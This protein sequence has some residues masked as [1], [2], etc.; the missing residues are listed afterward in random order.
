MMKKLWLI[1]LLFNAASITMVAQDTDFNKAEIQRALDLI[2]K[3]DEKSLIKKWYIQNIENAFKALSLFTMVTM[4][5]DEARHLVAATT[6]QDQ[7]EQ[8]K[9]DCDNQLEW[10]NDLIIKPLEDLNTYESNELADTLI[11]KAE[12]RRSVLDIEKIIP[13]LNPEDVVTQDDIHI[14]NIAVSDPAFDGKAYAEAIN[15]CQNCVGT[16]KIIDVEGCNVQR[17]V[18]EM[19]SYFWYDEDEAQSLKMAR[20]ASNIKAEFEKAG[21][22]TEPMDI[23]QNGMMQSFAELVN[24]MPQSQREQEKRLKLINMCQTN[25]L[26]N[27]SHSFGLNCQSVKDVFQ[28]LSAQFSKE[29]AREKQLKCDSVIRNIEKRQAEAKL[30]D[31]VVKI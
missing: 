24:E 21:E 9:R 10:L 5:C 22:A 31:N 19:E 28:N 3:A 20:V 1:C 13:M 18:Y 6:S 25:D 26:A 7:H 14:K 16:G 17:K 23:D 27:S 8:I 2:S 12:Y 30:I 29:G 15:A 4:C 11:H